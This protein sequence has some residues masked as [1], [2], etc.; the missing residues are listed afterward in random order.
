MQEIKYPKYEEQ[1][2]D[3]STFPKNILCSQFETRAQ[4]SKNSKL[5]S[6]D[7]FHSR[8]FISQQETQQ[9]RLYRGAAKGL[10]ALYHYQIQ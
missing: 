7:R 4:N 1:L 8:I 10:W 3:C 5:A 9:G 6:F 2:P